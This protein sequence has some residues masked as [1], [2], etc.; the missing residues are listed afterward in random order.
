MNFVYR[1]ILGL[2][3]A[4]PVKETIN[5]FTHDKNYFSKQPTLAEYV[6]ENNQVDIYHPQH[7]TIKHDVVNV[8]GFMDTRQTLFR[9]T[10]CQLVTELHR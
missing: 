10:I 2:S 9:Q 3:L 1:T 7:Q 5:L 4:Q 6:S 8:Y